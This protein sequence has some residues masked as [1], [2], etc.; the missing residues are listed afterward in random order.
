[1]SKI[2]LI[3]DA[4]LVAESSMWSA[5]ITEALEAAREL[6]AKTQWVGLTDVDHIDFAN[7]TRLLPII[8]KTLAEHIE[9]KLKE[10]NT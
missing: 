4:L 6:K 5:K 10:K 9:A 3:I 2:D 1:M 7:K 8:A